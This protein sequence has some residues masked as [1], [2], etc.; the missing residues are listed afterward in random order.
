MGNC[1]QRTKG[2]PKTQKVPEAK[3]P[4]ETELARKQITSSIVANGIWE[5]SRGT[6]KVKIARQQPQGPRS[7]CPCLLPSSPSCL[8][9]IF[10]D[11]ANICDATLGGSTRELCNNAT[12]RFSNQI[13]A[14]AFA[15][16]AETWGATPQSVAQ[17]APGTSPEWCSRM[18]GEVKPRAKAQSP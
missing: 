11:P 15:R 8:Q 12:H 18:V 1:S 2:L 3:S 17:Y 10:T 5:F 4:M 9:G 14:D 6:R 16:L 13:V 7:R